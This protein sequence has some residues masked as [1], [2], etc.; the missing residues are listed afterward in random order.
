MSGPSATGEAG[1]A[2]PTRR[3]P[4]RARSGGNTLVMIDSV[5]GM[6]NAPPMPMNA[7]VAMSWSDVFANADAQRAEAEHRRARTAARRAA[8]A[9]TEAAGGEQQAREHERVR[10]DHPLQLAV[11]SRRGRGRCVGIATLRIVL[12]RTI[13]SRLKQRT[14]RIHQRR[15]SAR[16]TGQRRSL[17]WCSSYDG[18]SRSRVPERK[19]CRYYRVGCRPPPAGARCDR[20]ARRRR[21][22]GRR[23]SG[24]GMR[25]CACSTPLNTAG[26]GSAKPACTTGSSASAWA[27]PSSTLPAR[28]HSIIATNRSVHTWAA[29]RDRARAAHEHGREEERVLAAEHGEARAARRPGS[30]ACRRRARRPPASRRRCSGVR[31]SSSTPRGAEVAAGADRD[32]V[33]TTGTGL[34]AATALKCATMPASDGRT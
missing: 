26:F 34:A 14:A 10:V 4:C 3:S 19:A 2:R 5:A 1:D 12:S 24:V 15:S 18:P 23:T 7:R 17:T 25:P 22:S 32:V 21:R 31:A 29:A 8:E 20:A 16:W 33:D 27:R 9:V 13:T 11:A 30:R 6:M 28:P